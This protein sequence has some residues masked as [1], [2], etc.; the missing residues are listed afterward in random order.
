MNVDRTFVFLS[1]QLQNTHKYKMYARLRRFA[2]SFKLLTGRPGKFCRTPC[3]SP[4]PKIKR[5]FSDFIFIYS[6][7]AQKTGSLNV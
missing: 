4:H 3:P 6:N 2:Y 7:D 5:N 1:N